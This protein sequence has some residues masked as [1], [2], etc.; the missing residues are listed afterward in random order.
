MLTCEYLLSNTNSCSRVLCLATLSNGDRRSF[1]VLVSLGKANKWAD[2]P[3]MTA[4]SHVV[5]GRL[6]IAEAT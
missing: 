5:S 4:F 6:T 1:E 3:C 2:G